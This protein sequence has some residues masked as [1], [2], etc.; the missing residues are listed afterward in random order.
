MRRNEL[1]L[2]PFEL[3]E[4]DL[5]NMISQQT[6]T[7]R[8]LGNGPKS[9]RRKAPVFVLGCP[10]SGTTVL[11][12]MLLSAGGFAVYRSESNVFNLLAP[13]FGGMRSVQDRKRLM[14]AW[15]N[16]ILFQVSGL[17]SARIT[18]R[19][20]EECHSGGD[21]LRIVMGEVAQN[22]G[23]ERWADCTP[24]HLLYMREIKRQIP[25]ALF[26]HIVRDGR[27]VALSYLRQGWSYPLLWD[28]NESLGVAGLYW[29]WIVGR[30]REAGKK[31]GSDYQEV[32][33]EELI[34]HPEKTLARLA[35]FIDHELDYEAIQR[36][37]IGSVSEP[38]TSFGAEAGR[39]DPVERWRTK[40]SSGELA[41]FEALVGDRLEELGY[42]LVAR[43]QTSNLRTMRLRATYLSMFPV[44]HWA[45]THTLLGR[46][47]RLGRLQIE[48]PGSK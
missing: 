5:V 15:L 21:F 18:A 23:V 46:K 11:Y 30:G 48:P 14:D 43:G 13:R 26:I 17:D 8:D 44:K 32:R 27:D 28:R 38:N 33:F 9:G 12:H 20:M 24:E 7:K 1:W 37:G 10:R 22:Q 41:D 34:T 39:F 47:V 35:E 45:K 2:P 36:V 31:L 16:S 3:G 6:G 42:P 40:M 4:H 19:V 29:E 25:D